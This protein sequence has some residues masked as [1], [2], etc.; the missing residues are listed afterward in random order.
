MEQCTFGIN[1]HSFTD[2]GEPNRITNLITGPG[3][4]TEEGAVEIYDSTINLTIRNNLIAYSNQR[5]ILVIDANWNYNMQLIENEIAFTNRTDGFVGGGIEFTPNL[6][7]TGTDTTS[8][9]YYVRRGVIARNIIHDCVVTTAGFEPCIEINLKDG[10]YNIPATTSR[11][12]SLLVENNNL[13]NSSVGIFMVRLDQPSLGGLIRNNIFRNTRSGAGLVI[14]SANNTTLPQRYAISKNSFYNNAQLGIDIRPDFSPFSGSQPVNYNDVGDV[15]NGPNDKLNFPIIWG[16]T[17]TAGSDLEL[18]GTSPANAVVEV[19]LSDNN[20]SFTPLYATS[21]SSIPANFTSP[22][23]ING[24]GEGR[25]LLYTFTEGDVNDIEAGTRSYGDD[26]TGV[27]GTRTENRWRIIIPAAQLPA[28]FDLTWR[29]TSTATSANGSTSEFGPSPTLLI[30]PFEKQGLTALLT[31]KNQ[32]RL[33]CEFPGNEPGKAVIEY[34]TDA[35]SWLPITPQVATDQLT[36][37]YTHTT[38]TKYNYYRLKFISHTGSIR[39][40]SVQFVKTEEEAGSN[41]F[42]TFPNPTNGRFG[43]SIPADFDGELIQLE[44]FDSEGRVVVANTSKLNNL[45]ILQLN[46]AKGLYYLLLKNIRTQ[47]II[48]TTVIIQ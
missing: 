41:Q 20:T 25:Q 19:Y 10:T 4:S 7:T 40:S 14:N 27:T 34:S 1:A 30:L 8:Y 36:Y 3:F 12:D 5:G 15:D 18:W 16:S 33:T 46:V 11:L 28:G 48:H 35:V 23:G 21:P 39:Y 26:G 6:R 47:K 38:S 43:I 13:Y 44:I 24:Y 31:A 37:S 32:V 45:Q 29:L 22:L 17:Y 2:P 9:Q 42:S